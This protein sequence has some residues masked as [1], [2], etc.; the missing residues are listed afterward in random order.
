MAFI[1][2]EYY[3]IV[4]VTLLFYHWSNCIV[5]WRHCAVQLVCIMKGSGLGTLFY[6]ICI[7]KLEEVQSM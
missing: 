5:A 2:S 1:F 6:A 7:I 4:S 3:I